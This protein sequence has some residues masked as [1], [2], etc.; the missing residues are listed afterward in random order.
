MPRSLPTSITRE[1]FA[2]QSGEAWL[3]LLTLSHA[4]LPSPIRVSSD[5]VDTVR[6]GETYQH[7]P[8]TLDLPDEPED[9]PPRGRLSICNV[10]RS[11]LAAIETIS[12]DAMAITITVVP[13]SDPEQTLAGPYEMTL[14]DIEADA[15]A[16]SGTLAIENVMND[17]YPSDQFTPTQF[18]GLFS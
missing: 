7:F 10:D 1:L 2:S 18:R 15:L 5:G 16:V 11:I 9:T 14:E 12:G 8:F 3:V 6:G 17:A 13:A 4:D